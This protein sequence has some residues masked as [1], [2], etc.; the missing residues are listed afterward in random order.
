MKE[1]AV[2]HPT[3]SLFIIMS[4]LMAVIAAGLFSPCRADVYNLHL[5]T[6]N[7]PDYTDMDSFV[8]SV[9]APWKTPQDKCIAIWRWGRR[10]RRQTSCARDDGRLIWDPILHYNSYGAMNCG[11]ISALNIASFLKL[12]YKA[13]YIQ[14]GDHTVSEVSWNDG[15]T[16]HLFD[17]SM[18]FFCYNHKGAVASCEEIK[19]AHGCALSGG[20]VEPGHFYLYHGAPQC[21]SHNGSEGWRCAAD[22]PVAYKRTLINGASS[23]TDGFSV[24]RYTQYGR[25]GHRYTLNLRPF[26]SYTRHWKPLDGQADGFDKGTPALY[27][28][29]L[30]EKDPDE[31]HGLHNI[32]G[33]GIW[34]FR[35]DLSRADVKDLFYD[36][37][38]IS[39]RAA[40]GQGPN[41]QP[42]KVG[43][44]SWVVFQISAANVITSMLIQ[45]S[46]QRSNP[47]DVLRIL[48]SR[49]AGIRWTPVWTSRK[50]GRHHMKRLLHQAV[51]GVTECLLK[52]EMKAGSQA[53]HVGL[54]TLSIT[55]LTQLNRRTLPKLT[56]GTNKIRIFADQQSA[57]TLLWPV[58]HADRYKET[59]SLEHNIVSTDKP[60]GIY[61]ATLG[62][63][64]NKEPCFAEWSLK[65]PTDLTG[66][67]YG[68]VATNRSSASYV[69]LQHSFDGAEYREFFRKSDGAFPFDRQ[70]VHAIGR[71]AIPAH[72]REARIKCEFYCRGGA[73]TYG[74]DGLQDVW[75]R[76]E[77]EPR[78][79]HYKPMQVTYRWTEHRRDGDVTRSH[80]ERIASLPH[81]YTINT[82]GFRDP[83]MHWVRVESSLAPMGTKPFAPGY[84]DGK[85]VG[86][87]C[88][89]TPRIYH[90]GTNVA[91]GKPYH[92]SRPAG[93]DSGNTDKDGR[94][95]TNGII[96]APTDYATHR[97]VQGAT[98]FWAGDD[99]IA[100]VL[101]LEAVR[102]LTA[103]R[104]STH[105]PNGRF[106][107]P[108]CIDVLVSTDKQDWQAAGS[109]L[110]NDIWD[111]PADY[112]PW[113][114]DDN[115]RY[116]A[117]PA[118]GRLAYAFPVIFDKPM[119]GRY[120]RLV[121]TPLAGRGAG[122]SE[123]EMFTKVDVTLPHH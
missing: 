34:R 54:D 95:L 86:A 111:P 58:L 106:C 2:C 49:T 17:S 47:D 50:T 66:I 31:Q 96:I 21:R 73:G 94:E 85:D 1:K 72:T 80:T 44:K 40:G 100:V 82:A 12:G 92:A 45:G 10:S 103:A 120:V 117:L 29:P 32:R 22:Q 63:A 28:R 35:P 75:I 91:L 61:K 9:T 62:S 3:N 102:T 11:V 69:S 25:Y 7:G 43:E 76:A 42:K 53:S 109:A 39:I 87:G 30:N 115:P 60:D 105:Q 78:N 65:V 48:V 19:A 98:A 90:W 113:E 8:Q 123:V 52:I 38:G 116:D 36:A 118:A 51:A 74:M 71:D 104:I 122:L 4:C 64:V 93:N 79:S 108:K 13:R 81:A 89:R 107:H 114:H 46:G 110:H 27:Y 14:L 15:R 5:C 101:D 6:D 20:V 121:I 112:E 56:L 24:S 84:S 77:H 26:Q 18:S 68:V 16:W 23:Y 57:S 88:E 99:P 55:T 70:V 37:K 83:T 67:T 59:V 119:Q 97:S 33:N 41:L